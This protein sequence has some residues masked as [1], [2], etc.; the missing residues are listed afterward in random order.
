[1]LSSSQ[2]HYVSAK[3]D[4]L[5]QDQAL[6]FLRTLYNLSDRKAEFHDKGKQIAE[7][8][9][10]VDLASVNSTNRSKDGN[11]GSGGVQGPGGRNSKGPGGKRDGNDRGPGDKRWRDESND[12]GR[13]GNGNGAKRHKENDLLILSTLQDNGY[14]DASMIV[15]IIRSLT[16]AFSI[17]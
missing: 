5:S 3:Y 7:Q 12:A 14:T 4:L 11:D 16:S 15:R 17:Q 9:Y 13:D 8:L 2:I 10:L 1:M 6:Q